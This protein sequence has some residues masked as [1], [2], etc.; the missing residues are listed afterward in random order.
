MASRSWVVHYRP[1][2]GDMIDRRHLPTLPG[3]YPEPGSR[4]LRR[5]PDDPD[6]AD[7]SDAARD[8]ARHA[9]AMAIAGEGPLDGQAASLLRPPS[10]EPPRALHVVDGGF[11]YILRADE[12]DGD[13]LTYRY[14]PG[15]SPRHRSMMAE[16]EGI[17]ARGRAA[18]VR[19]MAQAGDRP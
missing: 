13:H 3:W 9:K 4:V 11:V 2:S 6:S 10:G 5:S 17:Y 8:A 1:A 7:N 12:C 15:L 19:Q 18:A 16:V 14:S